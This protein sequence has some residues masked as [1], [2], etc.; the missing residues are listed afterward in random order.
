MVFSMYIKYGGLNFIKRLWLDLNYK[1]NFFR[2]L[3]IEFFL[4]FVV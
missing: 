2:V 4:Y 3:I 1:Y